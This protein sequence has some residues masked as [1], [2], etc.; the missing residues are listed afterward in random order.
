MSKY[1]L[2]PITGTFKEGYIL[3]DENEKEVYKCQMTKFKLFGASPFNFT[4]LITNKSE[5][6]TVGKVST[7]TQESG[8]D[9]SS[10][11]MDLMSTKSGFKYDG[12]KIFDYLHE[13][14]IRIDSTVNSEKVG[15]KY[16]VTFEGKQIATLANSSPKGKSLLTFNNYLDVECEEKDLDLVFLV[17]FSIARTEQTFYN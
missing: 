11:M 4:N 1:L 16:N 3:Y 17:A 2:K 12:Q 14:G 13:K 6:H 5:E 10:A 9:L 8:K 7:I 15:M